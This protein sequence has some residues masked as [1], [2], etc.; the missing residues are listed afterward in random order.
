MKSSG[1]LISKSKK[2][3]LKTFMDTA[4][5]VADQELRKISEMSKEAQVDLWNEIY[6][7]EMDRSTK[8]AGLRI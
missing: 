7:S 2:R 6:H 3:I 1:Q 4:V 8:E 5:N